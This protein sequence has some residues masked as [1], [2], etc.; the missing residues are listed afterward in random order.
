MSD[1]KLLLKT[2]IDLNDLLRPKVQPGSTIDYEWPNSVATLKFISDRMFQVRTGG[3]DA[4]TANW[5]ASNQGDGKYQYVLTMRESTKFAFVEVEMETGSNKPFNLDCVTY[6]DEDARLRTIP[7]NRFQ[8]PFA[9]QPAADTVRD[10]SPTKI[11]ELEGGN[12]GL[13]KKI[14]EGEAT[15]C[16]KCH[17]MRDLGPKIGPDLTNLV[18]RTYSVVLRDI[19]Q[20][21][22]AIN[23]DHLGQMIRTKDDRTLTGMIQSTEG[24]VTTIGDS[25]G[26]L[27]K[28]PSDQI[29]SIKASEVSVMP[30]GLLD[31]LSS[32]ELKHLMT[33]LMTSPPQMPLVSKHRPPGLRTIA[34]VNAVLAGSQPLPDKLRPLKI[35]L[36]AGDKDHGPEEHDYPAWQVQWRSLLSAAPNVDVDVAW[37]FPNETQLSTA[38]VLIFFQKGAWDDKRQKAMDTYFA[39]G[40]GAVYLH[41]AVNG[42]DRVSDF[43]E[44]IG[45]AS[46]GGSIRYRHGPLMLDLHDSDDP[47]LRNVPKLDLIDESYWLLTGELRNIKLL[48]TSKEDDQDQPQMWTYQ[49]GQGRVFVSIPGHY[50]WTF[51]DPI[52]RIVLLRAISWTAKEPI[53]RL[54]ELVLHGAR[55][56]NSR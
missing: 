28:I 10:N 13:G 49:P 31:K 45:L 7:L 4:T 19:R 36:V 3:S 2:A 56:T 12:W 8:L 40:G 17:S 39:R 15:K 41:W 34:E 6:T 1:G 5:N 44:R 42:N 48:A 14:F 29:D 26:N 33:F 46:R 47:I 22:F 24:G 51:D 30:S 53:D 9:K 55:V 25:N 54:N 32:E 16:A 52:F 37:P 23:P 18:H 43:S 21:S 11:A 35:V 20:P 27:I 38:D 50:S